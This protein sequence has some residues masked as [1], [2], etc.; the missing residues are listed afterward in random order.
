MKISI[1]DLIALEKDR[2]KA[3]DS[4]ISS[5]NMDIEKF[6]AQ[7]RELFLI[8]ADKEDLAELDRFVKNHV[9]D[10]A[11]EL[12]RPIVA[13]F[14]QIAKIQ[15]EYFSDLGAGGSVSATEKATV[16]KSFLDNMGE[17][18]QS[19][20][21]KQRDTL[22]SE[23]RKQI[24]SG[25]DMKA[26]TDAFEKAGGKLQQHAATLAN[27]SLAGVS[28]AYND[29]SARNAGLDHG[30]YSG[31]LTSRT[32]SFCAYHLD[33]IYTRE[34]IAK[35]SNGMLEP[36]IIY[37]GGYNC[38]HHWTW[39]DPDWD[40]KLKEKVARDIEKTQI[41]I[42]AGDRTATVF[43]EPPVIT[44]EWEKEY[45]RFRKQKSIGP[46]MERERRVAESLSR[47]G[48]RTKLDPTVLNLTGGPSDVI[49]TMSGRDVP[50]EIK[51]PKKDQASTIYNKVG[52][53]ARAQ[54]DL[55]VVDIGTFSVDKVLETKLRKW[56]KDFY[57]KKEFILL[58][59]HKSML[60]SWDFL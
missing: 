28:S 59:D 57:P 40:P 1:K 58:I 56:V 50:A 48:M 34:T 51:H 27:T 44:K 24:A 30:W 53:R 35:M 18:F 37:G 3:I 26:L 12:V 14:E 32:R 49:V 4:L 29:L 52:S 13:E 20:S 7:Y 23:I 36:V 25:P 8:V 17:E 5:A 6:V 54:A 19:L 22:R 2:T 21:F 11:V 55:I 42:G 41:S 39:V 60:R 31:T 9:D 47:L 16:F 33:R 46:N 38:R 43:Y 10:V 45:E 15:D